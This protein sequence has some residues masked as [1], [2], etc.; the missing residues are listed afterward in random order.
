MPNNSTYVVDVLATSQEELNL[1]T[2]RLKEPSWELI[3]SVAKKSHQAY[4][5]TATRLCSVVGFAPVEDG[6]PTHKMGMVARFSKSLKRFDENVEFHLYEISKQFPNALFLVECQQVDC[7][8][9]RPYYSSK[10]VV[11]AGDALRETIDWMPGDAFTPFR[12][13]YED[14]LPFGS[15]GERWLADLSK[16]VEVLQREQQDRSARVRSLMKAAYEA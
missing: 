10:M 15:L 8:D 5:Q 2:D 6:L 14:G 12:V 4:S 3:R 1:I 16:T 9:V 11:L 7:S 13:E